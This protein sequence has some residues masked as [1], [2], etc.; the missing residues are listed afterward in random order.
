VAFAPMVRSARFRLAGDAP[1]QAW[2]DM[3]NPDLTWLTEPN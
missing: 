1:R 3:Q 2:I